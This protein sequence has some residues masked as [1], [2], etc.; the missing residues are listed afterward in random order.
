MEGKFSSTALGSVYGPT[1]SVSRDGRYVAFTATD[2]ELLLGDTNG[3]RD[4]IVSDQQTGVKTIVSVGDDGA[5]GNFDVL[6]AMVSD[7]GRYVLFSSFSANLFSG[8]PPMV[9][10]G[11]SFYYLR[12]RQTSTTLLVTSNNS[13]SAPVLSPDGRYVAFTSAATNLVDYVVLTNGLNYTNLYLYDVQARTN[14]LVSFDPARHDGG[15]G[16]SREPRFSPNSLWLAFDSY[17]QFGP[18]LSKFGSILR[19]SFIFVQRDVPFQPLS[20]LDTTWGYSLFC[21]I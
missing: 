5:P 2:G 1:I 6:D 13:P 3:F 18:K 4:A 10:P 14:I 19:L 8:Q 17:A 9:T 20:F 16:H 11:V 7:D 15:L 12:D 21:C